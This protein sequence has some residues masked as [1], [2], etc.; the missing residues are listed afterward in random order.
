MIRHIA[1]FRLKD[2]FNGMNKA[3]ILSRIQHNVN[4]MR[5]AISS[6]QHIEVCTHQQDATAVFN[7]DDLCVLADFATQ[8]D[9]HHYFHHPVHRDAAGFAA[10]VSSSVHAITYE[11]IDYQAMDHQVKE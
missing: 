8:E 1:L 10:E 3:E 6:I 2:E 5:E 9:Y 7:A 4:H 11:T